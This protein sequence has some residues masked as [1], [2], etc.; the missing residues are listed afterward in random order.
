MQAD[1]RQRA[2]EAAERFTE[3]PMLVLSLVMLPLLL[4]PWILDL[5]GSIRDA[6]FV[7]DWMIW[8]MFALELGVK[9]YLAPARIIY[10]RRHWFDLCLVVLPFLRPLRVIRSARAIRV[11][12][13]TRAMIFAVRSVHSV[14]EILTEHGLQYVLLIGFLL[15]IGSAG[16]MTLFE[17]GGDGSIKDFDD[18]LWWAVTTITTVGYGDKFPVT[19]EGKGV[20]VLLMLVGISLFSLLT[21]NMAAFLV[22]PKESANVASLDDVLEQLRRLEAK[23]E[24]LAERERN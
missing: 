19:P 1:S 9:T 24:A 10:L 16:V 6:F 21:A 5:S 13:A 15:V 3:I 8:A 4:V 20:A 11:L 18:G 23:I 12:R 22:K 2:L 17:Q 14:K 7:I